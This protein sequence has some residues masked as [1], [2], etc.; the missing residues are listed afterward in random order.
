M[1]S[2]RVTGTVEMGGRDPSPKA[3]GARDQR[4]NRLYT[5]PTGT[6]EDSHFEFCRGQSYAEWLQTF[7]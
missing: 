6:I 1:L 5:G 3:G 2:G 7:I 4:R